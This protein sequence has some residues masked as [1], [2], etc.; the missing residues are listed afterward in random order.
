MPCNLAVTIAKAAVTDEQLLGL[1]TPEFTAQLVT[2]ALSDLRIKMPVRV[3][4]GEVYGYAELSYRDQIQISVVKG[5]VTVS[6]S[7]RE[8]TQEIT[9]AVSKAIAAGADLMFSKQI[10]TALATMTGKQPQLREVNVEEG[11]QVM[12]AVLFSVKY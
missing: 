8:R 1:L 12:P 10:A 9:D 7:T 11:G 2:A 6:A 3:S 4:G 5:K